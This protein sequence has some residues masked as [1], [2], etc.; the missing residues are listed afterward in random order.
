[1]KVNMMTFV[2]HHTLVIDELTE[3]L[4]IDQLEQRILLFDFDVLHEVQGSY[5]VLQC[6][7]SVYGTEIW[8]ALLVFFCG[9]TE[10]MQVVKS[11]VFYVIEISHG[12]PKYL[13][14][15]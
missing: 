10:L 5:D 15:V 1:M 2:C 4:S 9:R 8:I 12:Y 11:Y 6:L 14:I 7:T 13:S 3:R